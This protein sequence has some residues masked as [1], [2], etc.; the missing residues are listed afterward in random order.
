MQVE[1]AYQWLIAASAA[2]L[3]DEF[4]IH[5]VAA[6]FALAMAEAESG[7][8]D[9]AAGVGL[10]S[11]AFTELIADMFPGAASALLEAT[12][13][14]AAT[15]D[16]EEQSLRDILGMFATGAG[17]L[18]VHLANMIARRCKS[19]HHLWQDLGL[20]TRDELSTLMQRHFARMAAKN[21]QDM[22]WKK[23][24]YRMV[25]GSEG[26]TL[27]TSPVCS[28][29]PDFADCFGAED[30]ESRLAWARNMPNAAA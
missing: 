17:R 5:V 29:C 10:D 11:A 15:V 12:E 26:F 24:L 30:G 13:N 2:S 20:R 21:R 4:D 18:E 14:A 7:E 23:F 3:C 16:A 6:I 8:R 1:E 28:E 27:C 9:L 22:K 19:P 25:C